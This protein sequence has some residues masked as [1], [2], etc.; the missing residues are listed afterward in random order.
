MS[1]TPSSTNRPK[2]RSVSRPARIA[3][4]ASEF[5]TTSTPSPPVASRVWAAKSSDRESIT[6]LIPI[7]RSQAR[8]SSVPAVAST[9]APSSRATATAAIPVPPLAEWISTL[10]P[11]PSRATCR[12]AYQAVR[13]A[14]GSPAA[15]T[16]PSPAGTRATAVTGTVTNDPNAPPSR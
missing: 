12:S 14:T 3:A 4:P 10:S 11:A 1:R 16:G 8:F 13:K 5:R 7:P 2:G 15:A 9:R 6:G